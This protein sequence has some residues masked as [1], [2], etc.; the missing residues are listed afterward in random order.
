MKTTVLSHHGIISEEFDVFYYELLRIKEIALRTSSSSLKATEEQQE[1]SKTITVSGPVLALQERLTTFFDQQRERFHKLAVGPSSLFIQEAQYICV[2]MADEIMINHAWHGAD[3]WRQ[4]CLEIK[5]F[6]TQVAGE[7]IFLQIDSLLKTN[8]PL[9]RELARL[10]LLCLSLGFQGR[11]RGQDNL[12]ILSYKQQLF[13]F[14]YHRSPTL[15]QGD[16]DY[17]LEDSLKF[18]FTEAPTKG[19]PDLRSWSLTAFSVLLM[20]LFISYGI[21]AI[22]SEDLHEVLQS[23]FHLAKQGP[24]V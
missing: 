1:D 4:N 7:R 19:L 23:I 10:Y 20:Y 8:D 13:S 18:I 24:V 17:L 21:W 9:Q 16:R 14:I 15:I 11:F 5:I 6:Q 3:Y 12:Q 22:I 2:A